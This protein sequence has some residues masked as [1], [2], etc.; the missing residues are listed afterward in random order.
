MITGADPRQELTRATEE[1]R[2]I[3]EQSLAS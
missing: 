3:L 1:F 2:P